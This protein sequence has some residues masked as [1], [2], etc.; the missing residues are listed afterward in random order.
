MKTRAA[1]GGSVLIPV[2]IIC[3]GLVS[4]ALMFAHTSAMALRATSNDLAGRQAEMAMEGGARYAIY[5]IGAATPGTLPDIT[6]YTAEDMTVGQ[7]AFW[8]IGRT[9]DPNTNPPDPVYGLVDE[10]SKL[11]LNSAT[12]QM[13]D[14]LPGM[15]DD[16]AAAIVSWRSASAT[17]SGGSDTYSQRTI[18]FERKA[19][20]FESVEEMALLDG[21]D[22]S[23]F[24]GEDRN[25][26]GV[27]DTNE[28][29]DTTA[30]TQSNTI[31]TAGNGPG[32]LEYL[33]VFS[34]EAAQKGTTSL[35]MFTPAIR[36]TV[37]TA[38]G[39][40]LTDSQYQAVSGKTITSP[41]QL[42]AAIGLTDAE[43]VKAQAVLKFPS[44]KTGLVNVNTASLTV[45][46]A[47]PGIG[48]ANA[49]AIVSARQSQ[50]TTSTGL[51]WVAQT[52]KDPTALA[53]AG[54]WL[55]GQSGVFSADVAAVGSHGRG[56]RRTRF[57]IDATAGDPKIIYR[58]NLAQLGFALG[59]TARQNLDDQ[60]A[61][62]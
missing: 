21:A 60:R 52:L 5:L 58:R 57:I 47:I 38:I 18:P 39:R 26:N 44:L 62:R 45:L 61:Q 55:T 29:V 28:T 2:L 16:L 9:T 20:P 56:Y 22:P 25:L 15:T 46:T 14:Q 3:L 53:Q 59:R 36:Q 33:T 51:M 43:L 49:S 34:K 40:T 13:L 32:L 50:S 27:L 11:N 31:N 30:Y 54:I 24:Y 48:D 4:I 35:T 10:A 17:S 7:G 12:Q 41:L 37:E 42:G 1:T 6:T 23:L 19:G 8:I